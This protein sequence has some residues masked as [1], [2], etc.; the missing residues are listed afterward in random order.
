VENCPLLKSQKIVGTQYRA[1]LADGELPSEQL[2]GI[3]VVG[4]ISGRGDRKGFTLDLGPTAPKARVTGCA[5]REGLHLNLWSGVPR[6]TTLLWHAYWYL[7]NEGQ[8]TAREPTMGA[9]SPI[10]ANRSRI[11]V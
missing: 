3:A 8:P 11:G 4:N 6:K 1:H 2:I 9:P 7:G 10:V 5:S